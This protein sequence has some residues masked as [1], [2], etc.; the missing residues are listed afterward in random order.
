[1]RHRL[2][3][4]FSIL[5]LLAGSI[6]LFTTIERSFSARSEERQV[7][8]HVDTPRQYSLAQTAALYD[9]VYDLLDRRRQ[10]LEIADISYN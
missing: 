9:E 3:F 8:V 1:M 6:Y 7:T 2:S 4:V 10:E 5:L